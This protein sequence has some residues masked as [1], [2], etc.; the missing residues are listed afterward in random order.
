[1]SLA[2]ISLLRTARFLELWKDIGWV[3]FLIVNSE[4][5]AH[6]KLERFDWKSCIFSLKFLSLLK[7]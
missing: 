4:S 7:V 3:E 5:S 1:M 6:F 2:L